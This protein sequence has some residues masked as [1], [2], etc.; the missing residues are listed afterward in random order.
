[1]KI[2][3]RL[4]SRVFLP[5][6]ALLFTGL[7]VAQPPASQTGTGAPPKGRAMP[8]APQAGV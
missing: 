3:L 6:A 5:A 2:I 8:P 7:L 1:M 4:G